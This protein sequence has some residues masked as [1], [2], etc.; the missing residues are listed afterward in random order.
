[1]TLEIHRGNTE[2]MY[3]I[4]PDDDRHACPVRI[5]RRRV[6]R[7][8]RWQDFRLCESAEAA[9]EIILVMQE[10]LPK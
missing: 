5:Q 8:A 4:S 3:R 10:E 1:M 7:G 6:K 9:R 2:W